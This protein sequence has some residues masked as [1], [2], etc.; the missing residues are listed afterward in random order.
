[1][2]CGAICN[3]G[4]GRGSSRYARTIP[5]SQE[6]AARKE[7]RRRQQVADAAIAREK[8]IDDAEERK[9]R[10]ETPGMR[11]RRNLG[12]LATSSKSKDLTPNKAARA[13]AEAVDEIRK[14]M[15]TPAHAAP[16]AEAGSAAAY[17]IIAD[18]PARRSPRYAQP[19]QKNST[20]PRFYGGWQR[21]CNN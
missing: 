8:L 6:E 2:A 10:L 21:C 16:A 7:P 18:K 12:R 1:M 17:G 5:P 9:R 14:G 11:L 20:S 13:S 15:G 4:Q 3:A 19:P